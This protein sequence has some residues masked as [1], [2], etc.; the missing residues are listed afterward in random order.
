MYATLKKQLSNW[1][2]ALLQHPGIMLVICLLLS[3]AL[4]SGIRQF[5]FDA[6]SDTLVVEGDPALTQYNKM[7]NIFGGDD[8]VVLTY[9]SDDVL[10]ETAIAEID[11]LQGQMK[12]LPGVARTYSI[13][14]APLLESPPIPLESL[15]EGYKTLRDTDTEK[16]LAR[17]ELTSSPLFSNFLITTDGKGTAITA[18]LER[19]ASL[20][21]LRQ[22]RNAARTAGSQGLYALEAAY[23]EQRN[24]FIAAR[25]KLI[26][27]LRNIR[28][29]YSGDATL[30]ISGVPMITADMLSYVRADLQTFS[31]LVLALIV[32]LLVF[33]FRKTRWVVIPLLICLV[34]VTVTMGLLGFLQTPVTVVSSNFIS[35]LSII[36][37]SF[38]IHLIIRYRELLKS[39]ELDHRMRVEETMRSKFAPCLYTA[40]TTLFAFG[41]LLSSDILPIEDFGWMMCLGIVVALITTYL[42]F[43][44]ILLLLAPTTESAATDSR[45]RLTDW[46]RHLSVNWTRSVIIAALL[47]L[48]PTAYGISLIS[49]DNRFIDY[50][51]EDTDIHEGMT[52]IDENLGG[53]LPLDVYIRFEQ[54]DAGAG[55]FIDDF[56]DDFSEGADDYPERYWFTPDKVDVLRQMQDALMARP[57]VGKVISLASME[58]MARQFN[59]DEALSGLEIAYVLGELPDDVRNFLIRP[60]ASPKEGWLRV[61]AR[62]AESL[63]DFSKDELIQTINSFARKDMQLPEDRFIVTGMVVLFNDMLKQLADSQAR[64]LGYV[65]AAIFIMF[66]LLLGSF[67]LA[68]IGLV[69]NLLAASLIIAIMGLARIPLDMMTVTI[70]AVCI[71]IGVHDAI[72]YLY[73]FREEI[74]HKASTRQAVITSHQ[75]IG[76]AMYFTTVTVMAGFSI[77]ALSNFTPTV[78]FGLLTALSMALA[79]IANMTLLPS[80]LMLFIQQGESSSHLSGNAS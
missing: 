11:E 38:A 47:L 51:H 63:S 15:A 26:Q 73:R 74:T 32:L 49:F 31:L 6:S 34:T 12:K 77:L 64:T 28:D 17:V 30:F 22:K 36:S 42:L 27:Q 44:T 2:F 35:L 60:F 41:S 5:S 78:Y 57:E 68:L 25:A 7:A 43:P 18:F 76:H 66:S 45:I 1:Y 65:V 67:R 8:F 20:E 54:Y 14:D 13:L 21:E 48:L 23:T 72:H 58:E 70:A 71:G 40:L 69:P 10:S 9:G 80:L 19:D 16:E 3:A 39:P 55:D 50:F 79:L 24:Q 52:Y 56:E 4:I 62:I 29:D 37:I 61:N 53:T 33:F 59:D 46:F 75:T